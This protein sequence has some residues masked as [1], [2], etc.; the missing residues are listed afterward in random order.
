MRRQWRALGCS[1][2]GKKKGILSDIYVTSMYG[3][4]KMERKDDKADK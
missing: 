4:E 2:T 3:N 1:A